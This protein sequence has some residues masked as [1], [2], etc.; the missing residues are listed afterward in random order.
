MRLALSLEL[1]PLPSA[2][3]TQLRQYY[4]PLRHPRAPG[5]SLAGVR[6][7]VSPATPRGFPCFV[8]FPCVHAAATTPVRR[9]GVVF[10]LSPNRTSLPRYDGQVGPHIV[11]L[12]GCDCAVE[13]IFR[14][15]RYG[16][17]AV[18]DAGF[19]RHCTILLAERVLPLFGNT[20]GRGVHGVDL[21]D[22]MLKGCS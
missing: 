3:I 10:A 6:L 5:L 9:M 21:S 18:D 8:R 20:Y 19:L 15:I 12:S 7:A 16:P 1:R 11:S 4:G 14:T 13:R 22:L 17:G 2:G